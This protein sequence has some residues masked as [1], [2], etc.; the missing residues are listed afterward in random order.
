MTGLETR[1]LD[2]KVTA[3]FTLSQFKTG[4]KSKKSPIPC[5]YKGHIPSLES[6]EEYYQGI[7]SNGQNSENEKGGRTSN[8]LSNTKHA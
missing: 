4:G 8:I 5:P 3:I 1:P 7:E 6:T 2:S